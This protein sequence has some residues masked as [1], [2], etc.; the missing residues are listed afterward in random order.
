MF[1]PLL[2][3]YTD[4]TQIEETTHKAPIKCSPSQLV[5]LKE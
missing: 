5:A 3:A 1:Q 4:S 2:D